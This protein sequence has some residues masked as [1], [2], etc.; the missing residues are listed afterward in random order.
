MV[1]CDPNYQVDKTAA[2]QGNEVTFMVRKVAVLGAGVMGE[3]IAAHCA[4]ANV[5][6]VLFDL[7]AKEGDPNAIVKKALEGLKKLEPTPLA[8][9]DRVNYIDAANYGQ[10]LD[11]KSVV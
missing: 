4:N 3:Q 5:P 8:T 1:E 11:R 9:K 7:Q 10:D 6:V 2:K